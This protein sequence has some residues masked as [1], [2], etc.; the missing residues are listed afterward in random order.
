[1]IACTVIGTELGVDALFFF[2][3]GFF[4][5]GVGSSSTIST[6]LLTAST[7]FCSVVCSTTGFVG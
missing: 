2:F 1:V 3:F 6:T 7:G 4:V 5:A